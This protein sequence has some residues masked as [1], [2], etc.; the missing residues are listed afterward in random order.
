MRQYIEAVAI[1]VHRMR[2]TK[3]RLSVAMCRLR[4]EHQTLPTPIA[5]RR[6]V[7]QATTGDAA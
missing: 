7:R 4:S 2:P 6:A 5:V 3:A 1:D